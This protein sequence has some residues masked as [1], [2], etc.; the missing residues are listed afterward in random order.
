M[1]WNSQRQRYAAV[2]TFV[3]WGD[4]DFPLRMRRIDFGQVWML[5]RRAERQLAHTDR[6]ENGLSLRDF[7]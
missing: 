3:A 5:R 1:P 4:G 2:V 6:M 7:F